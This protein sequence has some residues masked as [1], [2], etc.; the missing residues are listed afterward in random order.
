MSSGNEEYADKL[1]TYTGSTPYWVRT[2]VPDF[3]KSNTAM[4]D[5]KAS[6]GLRFEP[7]PEFTRD[8]LEAR[9]TLLYEIVKR[10]WEV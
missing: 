3:Y 9:S 4:R 6:S 7:V 8:A 1:K 10:I 2:L 5:F